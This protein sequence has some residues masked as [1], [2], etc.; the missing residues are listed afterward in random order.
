MWAFLSYIQAFIPY[1]DYL[2]NQN[3]LN[4]YFS[5]GIM[6][7]IGDSKKLNNMETKPKYNQGAH[8]LVEYR[9]THKLG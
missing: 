7:T 1:F 2:I 9:L 5:S 8:S 6:L 3:L 4:T